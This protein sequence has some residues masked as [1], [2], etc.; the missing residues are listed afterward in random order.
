MLLLSMPGVADHSPFVPQ[1]S[2]ETRSKD[3]RVCKEKAETER[4][5]GEDG[6]ERKG[7]W[8]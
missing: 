4:K 6:R 5:R 3:K 1:A 7:L 2:M 8:E